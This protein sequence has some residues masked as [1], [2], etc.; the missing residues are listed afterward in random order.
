MIHT[1]GDEARERKCKRKRES[2]RESSAHA[3][4]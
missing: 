4:R 2:Q 3:L 1:P